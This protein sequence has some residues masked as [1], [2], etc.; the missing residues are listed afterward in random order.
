MV[1]DLRSPAETG[2]VKF[3]LHCPMTFA[4]R[5]L[6]TFI[7]LLGIHQIG[8]LHATPSD[9]PPTA[10]NGILDLGDWDFEKDGRLNLNGEWLFYWQ[11]FLTPQSVTSGD[12]KSP[13]GIINF[14]GYWNG[15]K[16]EETELGGKGYG[17]YRLTVL[18][19]RPYPSLAV[20]IK[21]IQTAY[22]LFVNGEKVA[23]AGTVG[24]NWRSSIPKYYPTVADFQTDRTKLDL[25]LHVSNYHHRKGGVWEN[26]ILGSETEIRKL[27]ED[28]LVVE[29]FLIG[30]ILIMGIYHLGLFLHRK[31]DRGSL[32]FGTFCM[33][34]ALRSMT[35]GER[36]LNIMLP[37]LSWELVHKLEYASFYFAVPLFALFLHSVF[38]REYSKLILRIQQVIGYLFTLLV[39]ITPGTIYT[40]SVQIYQAFT[41][42]SGIYFSYVIILAAIRR[43]EGANFISLG[44]FFLFIIT[45][46]E[47]LH[48]NQIIH[49]G[50]YLPFG[51]FVF[52]LSQ[53]I[54]IS[55]RFSK[56]YEVVESQT[57]E[58]IDTNNAY[59]KEIS[60]RKKLEEN[61]VDSH[62]KF[63]QSRIAIILGL[64]KLAEYRDEDTGAHL[65][66]MREYSKI[67]AKELSQQDDYLGYIT[68]AYIEDLYHS[69]ILHDIG[70]VGVA[71][72]VLLKPAKLTED[73]FEI[74]K[75]HPT[76]GGDA[77]SNVESR[78]DVQSFL[79]LGKEIAYYHHEK[80]D[81]SGY[82]NQLKGKQIPLSARIIALADVYDALTSERPYKKAFSHEKATSIINEGKGKHF[83]P[84]IVEAF[85]NQQELFDEIRRKFKDE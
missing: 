64:A 84:I 2:N 38:A 16:I 27:R 21:D 41:A 9:Q 58:L 5:I 62:K 80:W 68:D 69:S 51:M 45:I 37:E 56:T 67:L 73:E 49:T 65:E 31:K 29:I 42:L 35:T 76:I 53:A 20:K 8:D 54:L 79:T 74:I 34:I 13:T 39:I 12:I 46:N 60:E 19:S 59:R 61:L 25:V 52:I 57:L 40:H 47:I 32:F 28:T 14:P 82:P 72:S 17:T 3:Q 15:L 44:F 43:R 33:I 24:Q 77:I 36:Y 7:V 10:K 63:E 18:L 30:C 71:D 50:F 22:T 1:R 78:I 11:D 85:E 55:F 48:S 23:S 6:A 83:D 70:K 4:T 75:T 81:G 26:I 66:R